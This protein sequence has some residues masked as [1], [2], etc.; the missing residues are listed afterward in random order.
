MLN[1]QTTQGGSAGSL[2]ADAPPVS[3]DISAHHAKFANSPF[4]S[5]MSHEINTP[6]N[7]VISMIDLLLE[8]GLTSTQQEMAS[9][10]L[11]SAENLQ[12]L[13]NNILDFSRI[14]TNTLG[15]RNAPFDL[16]SQ[17]EILTNIHTAAANK[18]G[19]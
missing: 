17:V 2:D 12:G 5:N 7:G 19:L 11:T 1:S 9:I 13:L 14:E 16:L 18:K 3:A 4:L 8:S 15:L 6:M 10:A